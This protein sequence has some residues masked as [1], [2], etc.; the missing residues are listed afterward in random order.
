[1]PAD[2][3]QTHRPRTTPTHTPQ[4]THTLPLSDAIIHC[5]DERKNAP[6]CRMIFA[7]RVA[8]GCLAFL[9]VLIEVLIIDLSMD[10]C[11]AIKGV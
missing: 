3:T 5:L 10:I 7:K 9:V 6:I 8:S 2:N 4:H 1:M 11:P